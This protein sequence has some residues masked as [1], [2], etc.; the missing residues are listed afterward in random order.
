MKTVKITAK[1]INKLVQ[2]NRNVNE[3]LPHVRK[4]SIDS[5]MNILGIQK[6]S[7]G[8]NFNFFNRKILFDGDDFIDLSGEDLQPA[9]K[10]IFCQ[11]LINSP[12]NQI[13]GS[14]RLVTFREFSG[15]GPLFSRVVANTNKTI[16]QTF[17]SKPGTLDKKCRQILGIPLNNDS[18]DLCFQFKAL[19]KIPIILQFNAADEILPAN[20]TFLFQD[21]AQN[22]VDLKSLA[23][24]GTYLIGALIQ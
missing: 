10:N 23:T 6:G 18:F 1:I 15:A 16:E 21:D 11:Y 20:S 24:I 9:I 8:Y 4:M 19:P 2:E 5:T 7:Q 22:Y 3:Y 14:G 13:Q 12:Q 17:S